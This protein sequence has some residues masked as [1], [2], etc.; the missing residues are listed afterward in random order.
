M[1]NKYLLMNN[2]A[3]N[4][5]WKKD[6]RKESKKRRR[7]EERGCFRNML[8]KRC[9]IWGEL[10]VVVIVVLVIL[11]LEPRAFLKNCIPGRF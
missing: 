3:V 9:A 6:E 7:E 2:Y 8:I 4:G 10:F 11:E 1:P 5:I